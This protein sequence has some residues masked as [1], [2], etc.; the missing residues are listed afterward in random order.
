MPQ[1]TQNR[2]TR[3]RALLVGTA[4]T[5]AVLLP[6]SGAVALS[7]SAS[8]QTTCG[9]FIPGARVVVTTRL[10]NDDKGKYDEI[11]TGSNA[12]VKA[13]RCS[14]GAQLR[15]AGRLTWT[16]TA[17]GWSLDS[18]S[19]SVPAGFSCGGGYSSR[20]AVD[21]WDFSSSYGFTRTK[22]S[23]ESFYFPEGFGDTTKVCSKV[24]GAA[25]VGGVARSISATTCVSA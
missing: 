20:S 3:R 21:T 7:G 19:A 13:Y 22:S 14:D 6:A 10:N 2:S 12:S 9:A 11:L 8:N 23:Y 16:V 5:A 18:C 24:S 25:I 17:S 15:F 1:P 4:M